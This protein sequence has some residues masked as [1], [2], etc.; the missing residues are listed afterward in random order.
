M[1]YADEL[2]NSAF[3]VQGD[4]CR[5]HIAKPVVDSSLFRRIKDAWK[6]LKGE[7]IAV[8]FYEKNNKT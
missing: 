2:E 8:Q 3:H 6:T 7:C 1:I 5:W 4:D